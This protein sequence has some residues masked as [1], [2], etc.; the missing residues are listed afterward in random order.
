M[1]LPFALLVA[2]V[3]N[4]QL[5]S[6]K[7]TKYY[8]DIPIEKYIEQYCALP[9]SPQLNLKLFLIDHY[10][11]ENQIN[12]QFVRSP[13]YKI[14]CDLEPTFNTQSNIDMTISNLNEHFNNDSNIRYK[15][16]QLIIDLTFTKF[17]HN[18]RFCLPPI[19]LFD[20]SQKILFNWSKTIVQQLPARFQSI[21]L[22][23][24]QQSIFVRPIINGCH[25]VNDLFQ[26]QSKDD[27]AKLRTAYMNCNFNQT[28]LNTSVV[29]GVDTVYCVVKFEP[30]GNVIQHY[31]PD[32]QLLHLLESKY[33]FKLH[34]NNAKEV[35]GFKENETWIGIVGHLVDGISDFGSCSMMPTRVR[36]QVVDF[37]DSIYIEHL[38][39]L[40]LE[41]S[42][43]KHNFLTPHEISSIVWLFN[44][45]SLITYICIIYLIS[46]FCVSKKLINKRL[47]FMTISV[48]ILAVVVKQ[49]INS[50]FQEK[51]NSIRLLYSIWLFAM[52]IMTN[53]YTSVFYSTLTIPEYK[54]AID[55]IDDLLTVIKDDTFKICVLPKSGINMMLLNAEPDAGVYYS[56]AQ[57]FVRNRNNAIEMYSK[58][59]NDVRL[60]ENEKNIAFVTL[61]TSSL[62]SR[63]TYATKPIHIGSEPLS[64]NYLAWALPKGSPLKRPFNLII[65]RLTESGIPDRWIE[66]LIRYRANKI[67]EID[68]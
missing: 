26:P 11:F 28:Y 67:K 49:S 33:N 58:Y 46:R 43:K 23:N 60:I 64:L 48:R 10:F 1:W 12:D 17:Y 39:F 3:V 54:K 65:N 27:F 40:T 47:S 61:K 44:V 50:I 41:P 9:Y 18:C 30:D 2:H 31:S 14:K 7:S 25:F 35:W 45:I 22:T 55:T 21:F 15:N 6:L 4:G 13:L 29:S 36:R 66:N 38:V 34:F 24:K 62:I 59:K 32:G 8:G 51:I 68:M 56:I 52:L 57:N 19:V 42:I 53:M 5:P 37:T 20:F 16:I 63:Y